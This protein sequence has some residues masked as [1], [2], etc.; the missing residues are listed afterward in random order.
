LGNCNPIEKAFG[1]TP[2]IS[3]A[4]CFPF[5]ATV[6]YAMSEGDFPGGHECSRQF[7]GFAEDAGDA[8]TFLI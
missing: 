2:D 4:F 7:V 6:L 3:E 1:H 8:L 5:F